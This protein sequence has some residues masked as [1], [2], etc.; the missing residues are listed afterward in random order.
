MCWFS[1]DENL[2]T[3]DA[4]E[5]EELV[6]QELQNTSRRWV[7]S[8]NQP[9]TAV[10]LPHRCSLRLSEVPEKLQ[11][12]LHIGSEAIAVF[13]ESYVPEGAAP[14][15]IG[16]LSAARDVLVFASGCHMYVGVLP[17]GIRIDV[18]SA[19][20]APAEDKRTPEWEGQSVAVRAE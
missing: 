2:S 17:L 5:G 19:G 20:V 7:V 13:H 1:A 11:K 15:R 12:L 6:V 9:D 4:I 10:C 18:L 16:F 3:R 8:P 14:Q